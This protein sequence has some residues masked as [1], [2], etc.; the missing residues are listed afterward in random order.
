MKSGVFVSGSRR[1]SVPSRRTVVI[2]AV[3]LLALV[4]VVA[5][6]GAPDLLRPAGNGKGLDALQTALAKIEGPAI[7]VFATLSGLGLIAGGG[8]AAMGMQQGIR[9]MVTAGLAGGGVLLG[10]GLIA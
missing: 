4:A 3:A 2:L 10:K 6:I 7:A 9:I 5:L 8:M 1:L